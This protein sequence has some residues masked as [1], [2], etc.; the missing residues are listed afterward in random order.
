MA[1]SWLKRWR[2]ALLITF[3]GGCAS[4]GLSVNPFDQLYG[5]TQPINRIV[6]SDSAAGQHF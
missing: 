2:W 1:V 4:V 6:A 5:P 3:L